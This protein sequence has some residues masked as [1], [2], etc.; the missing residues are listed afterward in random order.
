MG[1]FLLALLVGT[2]GSIIGAG[3]G[4]AM[5]AGLVLFFDLA[6]AEAVATSSITI[7]F[8]QSAGAITYD[9]KGLVDRPTATWFVLG[10]VPVAF[11]S[12]ALLANRIPERTF[13]LLIGSLLVA[14]AIF[15][16]AVRVPETEG[17]G[18]AQPR[19]RELT[20]AG[21]F[22]GV[23]TGAFG[24]GAGLVTV[25]V[26]SWLRRLRPHRA[27][28]TTSAIGAVAGLAAS[29]GHVVAGNPRWSYLPFV[30]A[31]AIIGGRVGANSAQ[32]LSPGTVQ[33]LLAIG[34]VA[35]GLPVLVRGL[36]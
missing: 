12:A 36:S 20:V 5:V 21:S 35:A 13:D 10:S 32:R 28:A 9:R 22:T 17:V 30:I 2:Y 19:R 8:V 16:V 34:L 1:L 3:G 31:G 4:F 14:L 11:V 24:V 26:I 15:V 7:L 29:I 6:G 18:A 23:L 33:L 25:P 27:S